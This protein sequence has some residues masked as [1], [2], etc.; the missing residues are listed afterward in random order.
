MQ[1]NDLIGEEPN[2]TPW[3]DNLDHIIYTQSCHINIYLLR[4]QTNQNFLSLTEF[5]PYLSCSI[6]GHFL[7]NYELML[8][9]IELQIKD[10]IDFTEFSARP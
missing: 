5:G 1:Q 4:G 9:G 10:S 8:L 6:N 3:L 7:K 2:F